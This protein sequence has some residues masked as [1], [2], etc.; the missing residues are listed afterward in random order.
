MLI[1]YN[2]MY[3]FGFENGQHDGVLVFVVLLWTR[4]L[5]TCWCSSIYCIILES[6]LV[7]VLI[8]YNCMYYLGSENGQFVDV[9]AVVVI[10]GIRSWPTC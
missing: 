4:E 9:L 7:I 10:F 6:R 1:S 8:F 3:Y 2:I 5:S